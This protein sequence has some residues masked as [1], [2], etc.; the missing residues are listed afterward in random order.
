LKRP[1]SIVPTSTVTKPNNPPSNN[2]S[3]QAALGQVPIVVKQ[4]KKNK[5]TRRSAIKSSSSALQAKYPPPERRVARSLSAKKGTSCADYLQASDSLLA[6]ENEKQASKAGKPDKHLHLTQYHRNVLGINP[7]D[8]LRGDIGEFCSFDDVVDEST[9]P[10]IV[11][12]A[13]DLDSSVVVLSAAE[14]KS[15]ESAKAEVDSVCTALGL[16]S[17]SELMTRQALGESFF[18]CGSFL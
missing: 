18:H 2:Y 14:M 9:E 13:N 17:A 8:T 5:S 3:L 6:A 12:T 4:H 7:S 10:D 11:C 16:P 15:L 1:P